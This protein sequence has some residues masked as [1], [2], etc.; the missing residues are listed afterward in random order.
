[1]RSQGIRPSVVYAAPARPV[2][3]KKGYVMMLLRMERE[4]ATENAYHF[5]LLLN[6]VVPLMFY[7][8]L[9]MFEAYC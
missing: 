6:I 3:E 1:V 8:Q 5:P 9:E 2:I 4:K 7:G